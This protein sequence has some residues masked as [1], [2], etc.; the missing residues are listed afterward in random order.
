MDSCGFYVCLEAEAPGSS[1]PSDSG[2]TEQTGTDSGSS[3]GSAGKQ[4]RWTCTYAPTDPQPPA[5]SLD[6]EGH[7]PGDGMVYTQVCSFDDSPNTVTRQVWAADPP[8]AQP[9]V[10]PAELARQAVEKMKLDG[11]EIASP[12]AAGT[13]AVGVPM[14]LWLDQSPTTYGPNSASASA[15]G[16]TVTATARVSRV[17]WLMGDGQA[18]TCTS[19]GTPYTA[20]R[21]KGM[22]PDCGH[23]YKRSSKNEAG[24]AYHVTATS[25]WTVDWQV[26]GGA[27]QSGQLTETRSTELDVVIGQVKVLN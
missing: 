7:E 14:W 26:A 27:A 17:D 10:D 23:L 18:V 4:S 19:P 12:R 8:E 24:G 21:G 15:G 22:S 9:P 3:S 13:Y 16:I 11:P 20:A 1:G 6:W 2:K 25:T 5:G